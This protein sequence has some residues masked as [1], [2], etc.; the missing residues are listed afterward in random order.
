MYYYIG[1]FGN[2]WYSRYLFWYSLILL[3]GNNLN[4]NISLFFLVS[5]FYE[6]FSFYIMSRSFI[7]K[8]RKLLLGK[9]TYYNIIIVFKYVFYQKSGSDYI[10]LN[11][12]LSYS[13][14]FKLFRKYDI[15]FFSKS[16]FYKVNKERT[17]FE[18]KKKS[19]EIAK[20]NI[21]RKYEII[22]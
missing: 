3:F 18:I 5:Y 1:I 16:D 21:I 19:L 15:T 9:I 14:C 13:A 12:S 6:L 4:F 17:R 7:I 8:Y 20:K 22:F 11:Y 10:K 2:F